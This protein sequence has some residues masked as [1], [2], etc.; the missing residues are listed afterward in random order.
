[1]RA[2]LFVFSNPEGKRR[3]FFSFC[4][5]VEERCHVEHQIDVCAK[6]VRRATERLGRKQND[7][8]IVEYFVVSRNCW[9]QWEESGASGAAVMA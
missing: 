7:W 6:R 4:V 8:D 1:M 3:E 9:G 5:C 2:R